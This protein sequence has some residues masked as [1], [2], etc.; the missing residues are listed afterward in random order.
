M[1]SNSRDNDHSITALSLSSHSYFVCMSMRCTVFPISSCLCDIHGP[2]LMQINAYY[3]LQVF[4]NGNS[5]NKGLS[6]QFVQKKKMLKCLN[7]TQENSHFIATTR[8][9][10]IPREFKS[11]FKKQKVV[12]Y[13][14]FLFLFANTTRY[15]SHSNMLKNE[16]QGKRRKR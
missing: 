8:T 9:M 6:S 12:M 16:Q 10:W 3:K 15:E 14:E 7:V 11:V 2:L 13:W 4:L 1:N 5:L